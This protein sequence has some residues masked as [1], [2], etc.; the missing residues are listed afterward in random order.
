MQGHTVRRLGDFR[1]TKWQDDLEPT[2]PVTLLPDRL[3]HKDRWGV[4][5]H[6]RWLYGD[7]VTQ[8]SR[9]VVKL[10]KRLSMF[11]ALHRTDIA[12]LQDNS[13]TAC[14]MKKGRSASFALLR[15]LRQKAATSL[16][17]NFYVILPWVQS[18]VQ[19]AD[20]ASRRQ[21]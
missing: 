7:H 21:A 13:P 8:E 4:L 11:P 19:P 16:I 17:C 2:V 5:M 3:F 6:G 18:A 15:V 20:E 12:T 14:A 10:L 9:A 1:G